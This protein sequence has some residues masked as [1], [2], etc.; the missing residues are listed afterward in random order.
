MSVNLSVYDLRDHDL[1]ELIDE[2]LAKHG[3]PAERLRIEITGRPDHSGATP[4]EIRSDA[5]AA[6][7]QLILAV[8]EIARQYRST[9]ATVGRLEIRPNSVT[10]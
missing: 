1:P 8:E 4:M 10:T 7:S 6:A 2:A 3:V 5:L 9:A